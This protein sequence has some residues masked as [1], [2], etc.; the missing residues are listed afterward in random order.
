MDILVLG[1]TG[2]TGR[3]IVQYLAD[4]PE[5]SSFS[6][7]IAAR[8]RVKL[9]E[10]KQRLQLD[11]TIYTLQVDVTDAIQV[12]EAVKQAKVIINTVGP[13]W[14]WGTNVVRACALNGKHYVDLT[15]ETPWFHR[16]IMQYIL[17]HKSSPFSNK[18]D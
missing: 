6:L 12:D 10:L 15:A 8:S 14:R 1:A 7:G 16:I 11:D 2:F 18:D 3:L 9:H 5:R 13:Y 17:H 4:H